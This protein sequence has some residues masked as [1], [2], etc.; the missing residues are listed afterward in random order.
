MQDIIYMGEALKQ[1]RRAFDDNEVPI[2][3]VIVHNGRIIARAHNQV[4]TLNDPTAHAEMIA[5]TQAA[6]AL[7]SKWLQGASV[8]VTIEPCQMCAGA[9]VLARIERLIFGADDPKTGAF[10]SVCDILKSKNLNHSFE[11]TRGISCQE[12]SFIV[13]EFFKKKRQP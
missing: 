8:Y 5:I 11:V 4:E 10:G 6:S 7:G 3:C 12:S 13:S 1:A 2:G 9:L